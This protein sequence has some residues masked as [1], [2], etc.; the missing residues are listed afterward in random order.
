MYFMYFVTTCLFAQP[1]LSDD[2]VDQIISETRDRTD[3]IVYE[4][5]GSP[6]A[7]EMKQIIPYNEIAMGL[8]VATMSSVLALHHTKK[9]STPA[10]FDNFQKVYLAGY[11]LAT[12]ADWLQGPYMY[13]L[14]K[15]HD[16]DRSQISLLFVMGYLSS[17]VFGTIA[18]S[19]G[20]KFGRKVCCLM[21]CVLYGVS[22]LSKHAKSYSWLLVGRAVGGISTSLLHSCFEPWAITEHRRLGFDSSLL[23]VLF[24]NQ[25]FGNSCVAIICGLVGQYVA[26]GSTMV[27]LVEG[28]LL[29]YGGILWAFDI[30]F[31]CLVSCFTVITCMWTDNVGATANGSNKGKKG[32][33]SPRVRDKSPKAG[34]K[35]SKAKDDKPNPKARDKSPAPKGK[36]IGARIGFAAALSLIVSD[37]RLV[38]VGMTQTAFEG[39]MHI[40][41]F[42]WT[43]LLTQYSEKPPHGLIF[44][45]FMMCCMIGS[46][47]YKCNP[48]SMPP[49]HYVI[50][51]F[52]VST[53]AFAIPMVSEEPLLI[54][55]SF[56]LF[57]T[58]VG[59]YFPA[60]STIK[61]QLV[62]EHVRTTM[63]N[64]FRIPLNAFVVTTI[65][66]YSTES[67]SEIQAY[68]MCAA[69]M[70]IATAL[71]IRYF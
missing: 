6:P 29:H 24:A 41:I 62:P 68:Q 28:G 42:M 70:A 7:M 39:S 67:I 51:I 1:A 30:S 21:Y 50:G 18:G 13:A 37:P 60:F 57:E 32:K 8:F 23:S 52:C 9:K 66:L 63:Y 5:P 27:P 56:L 25:V 4:V 71:Q 38:L 54:L 40:F 61:G 16:L 49:Q 17:A 36:A 10:G 58:C 45:I 20:D 15:E 11:L 26:G 64:L 19:F 34:D 69:M 3:Q 33:T 44:A 55:A 43:P 47:L 48:L 59:V 46:V 14:Y 53:A 22:V 12:S 31:L 35:S 65:T 2:Q